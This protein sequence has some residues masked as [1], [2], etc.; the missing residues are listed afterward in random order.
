MVIGMHQDANILSEKNRLLTALKTSLCTYTAAAPAHKRYVASAQVGAWYRYAALREV[1]GM[2]VERP[3]VVTGGDCPGARANV[4]LAGNI[5]P[6][7]LLLSS[8]DRS[9]GSTSRGQKRRRQKATLDDAIIL[10]HLVSVALLV[11]D[12]ACLISLLYACY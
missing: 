9:D 6:L 12:S 7:R 2:P 3:V 8:Q 11:I 5:K 1:Y 4:R 10:E